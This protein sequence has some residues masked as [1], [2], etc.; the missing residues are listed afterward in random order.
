MKAD[1]PTNQPVM[2]LFEFFGI[3]PEEIPT[4][5]VRAHPLKVERSELK[6]PIMK[7]VDEEKITEIVVAVNGRPGLLIDTMNGTR[8]NVEGIKGC[9]AISIAPHRVIGDH[10][11]LYGSTDQVLIGIA[12]HE[13]HH[14]D[15]SNPNRHTGKTLE[16]C[17]N[18]EVFNSMYSISWLKDLFNGKDPLFYVSL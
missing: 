8:L 5:E 7:V 18:C 2:N 1:Q 10:A 14:W 11:M 13:Y 6:E 12:I 17:T 3:N 4:L 9:I 15:N 16:L